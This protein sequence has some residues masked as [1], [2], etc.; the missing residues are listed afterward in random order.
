MER[1]RKGERQRETKRE[2]KTESREKVDTMF[3]YTIPSLLLQA[4]IDLVRLL[5]H[6]A[7]GGSL[8]TVHQLVCITLPLSASSPVYQYP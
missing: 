8:C 7:G 6:I 1:K 3:T 4:I 2:T 5:I